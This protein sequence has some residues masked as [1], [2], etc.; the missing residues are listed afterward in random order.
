MKNR[1]LL[2]GSRSA[3]TAVL[4][5]SIIGVLN[6]LGARNEIRFDLTKNKRNTLSEQTQ[7]LVAGLKTP[8]RAVHFSKPA[9]REQARVVL[10][11]YRSLNPS[12]FTVEFVD[13]DREPLRVR[14][15]GITRAGVL[16]LVREDSAGAR[17]RDIKVDDLTEEKITHS[18][19]KLLN[20]A[21]RELCLVTGHGEHSFTDSNDGNGFGEIRKALLAQAYEVREINLLTTEK[22]PASCSAI[23]VWGPTKS[24]FSQ[25]VTRLSDYLKA[26]GRAIIGLDL[27]L[28]DPDPRIEL[29]QLLEPWGIAY[30]RGF[31]IDPTI[32]A[33]GLDPTFLIAKDFSKTHPITRTFTSLVMLPFSRPI[34]QITKP[35]SKPDAKSDLKIEPLILT[36]SQSWSETNFKDLARGVAGFNPDQDVMGVQNPAIAVEGTKTR[37]VAFGSASFAN[38]ALS[39]KLA[40]SDLF[41]NAVAW[42]L[43]DETSISIRPKENEPGKF[44]ITGA[45]GLVILLL[46]AALPLLSAAG[47]LAFW[48][49]RR[50]L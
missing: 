41:L 43:E 46:V 21:T 32:R 24:F 22:V 37:L 48:A 1:A 44:E 7:K 8:I 36:S 42:T 5:L 3:L 11:G 6:F 38:N 23:A 40:N 30:G 15:A 19:L 28:R 29:N 18:L 49:Y 33:E 12:K 16:Q 9:A 2:F 45:Q 47:G 25:E 10:D 27:T 13:P 34:T 35:D 39:S 14:Q 17:V 50:K 4:V 31:V 26:G 20:D